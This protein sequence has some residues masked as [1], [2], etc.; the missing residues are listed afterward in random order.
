MKDLY[1]LVF[2]VIVCVFAIPDGASA[3]IT[4]KYDKDFPKAGAVKGEI[5]VS[6]TINIPAVFVGETTGVGIIV[7]TPV[8]G[9]LKQTFPINI[10]AKQKMN[11][12][13]TGKATGLGGANYN[14]TVEIEVKILNQLPNYST[15]TARSPP[16]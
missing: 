13:W 4:T 2:A 14:V 1:K 16:K 5:A 15:D 3:Q 12:P 6:G 11:V 7:I 8:G 9:G 10:A